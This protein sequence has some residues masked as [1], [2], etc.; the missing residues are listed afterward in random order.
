MP[1]SPRLPFFTIFLFT[2]P[3]ITPSIYLYHP[4]PT[5]PP[6]SP[7]TCLPI[8][9]IIITLP[10]ITTYLFPTL[11]PIHSIPSTYFLLC[12]T[13]TP[14]TYLSPILP[15]HPHQCCPSFIPFPHPCTPFPPTSCPAVVPHPPRPAP[16][17]SPG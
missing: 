12:L 4:T 7:C 2:C 8:P 14:C 17:P 5:S 11:S 16:A 13:S 10:P 6:H 9:I 3:V 1:F 15:T